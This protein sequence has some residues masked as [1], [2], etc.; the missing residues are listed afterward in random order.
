MNLHIAFD[1]HPVPLSGP[2]PQAH[3]STPEKEK[4]LLTPLRVPSSGSNPHGNGGGA[5]TNAPPSN[6]DPNSLEADKVVVKLE[7]P[8]ANLYLY[9]TVI[10]SFMHL[11]ENIF[12]E[13]QHFTPM[14][15]HYGST[16]RIPTTGIHDNESCVESP[17]LAH[18]GSGSSGGIFDERDYR[19]I[20]VVLDISISNLQAHLLKNCS[21]NDDPCPFAM[22]EDISFEMDKKYRETRLQLILSPVVVRSGSLSARSSSEEDFNKQGHLLL[23][24]LQF[25]GHAMFSELDRPL[26]SDTLE[27]GWLIEVQCGSLLGKISAE[28]L[29]NVFVCLETFIHLAVDKENVLKHPRPYKICQHNTNQK[30]CAHS[31]NPGGNLCATVE[32]VKYKLVRFLVDSVDVH[33]T[34]KDSSLRLQ[35]C[36]IRLAACNLH[37]LNTKQGVSA[38]IK[39]VQLQQYITSNFPLHRPDLEPSHHRD[40]WIETG[41]VRFGPVF[42]EGAI[43]GGGLQ[44]APSSSG[45]KTATVQKVQHDFL[46]RHDNKTKRLWFLWPQPLTKVSPDRLGKC[47][48]VGGC[49]FFGANSNGCGFFEPDA[50][51]IVQRKNVALPCLKSRQGDPGYGQSILHDDHLVAQGCGGFGLVLDQ[52]LPPEWPH[53]CEEPAKLPYSSSFGGGGGSSYYGTHKSNSSHNSSDT[54]KHPKYHRSFSNTKQFTPLIPGRKRSVSTTADAAASATAGRLPLHKGSHSKLNIKTSAE[55]QAKAVGS[56]GKLPKATSMTEVQQQD[57]GE[58]SEEDRSS[59]YTQASSGALPRTESLVSD[60]LS[61]YSLDEDDPTSAASAGKLSH[62]LS[63]H[64]RRSGR[65][66]GATGGSSSPTSTQYETASQGA[67]ASS[68]LSFRSPLGGSGSGGGASASSPTSTQYETANSRGFTSS[69][70]SDNYETASQGTLGRNSSAMSFDTS[71][72]QPDSS[73]DARTL[74]DE[75]ELEDEDDGDDTATLSRPPSSASFISA[76]SEHEDLDLVD[77]HMQVNKP[78][79]DSPLLMSSYISHLTQLRCSYWRETVPVLSHEPHLHGKIKPEL[80]MLE[81]GFSVIKMMDK[82]DTGG[83]KRSSLSEDAGNHKEEEDEDEGKT[84][85]DWDDMQ[86]LNSASAAKEGR[87]DFI[88]SLADPSTHRTTLIVKFRGSIDIILCP[89]MLQSLESL[90]S[91]LASTFKALHPVDVVNHLH[92]RSVDRVESR[93]TLKKEKSLDLQEKLIVEPRD[94]KGKSKSKDKDALASDMFR[95]FEK[96]TSS[97]AQASVTLPKINLMVL[98]ASVV[99]EMCTFSALDRVRDITCVSLLALG[100]QGTTFQFSKTSQSKKT[101]QIYI[102]SQRS[103]FGKKKKSKYKITPD[104]RQNEPFTFESS[105]TQ[106][107]EI[108]MNGSLDKIH[109]QLRR[110]RNNSSIL[111]EALITAIPNHKSKVFFHYVDVPMLG[112]ERSSTPTDNVGVLGQKK[113]ALQQQETT[114]AKMGYNMCECGFE[115]INIKVAKRSC[116]QEESTEGGGGGQEEEEEHTAAH[117]PILPDTVPL[118]GDDSGGS[119]ASHVAFE[120]VSTHEN[121]DGVSHGAESQDSK[122][123]NNPKEAP[124]GGGGG[125]HGRRSTASGS[126]ELKTTWFNFAAPPKTPISKKIDFTK[127]DWNLL[128]TAS[129]SIDAWLGPADRLQEAFTSCMSQYHRRVGATMASLMADALDV[130][131]ENFLKLTKYDKLTALSKTLRDDPS[132]Q[133]C[134]ILLKFMIRGDIADIEANLDLKGVPPLTTLR[135]GIVVLSRQ[136]KNALYTPILI[137]YNLRCRNLKSIYSTQMNLEPVTEEG[138]ELNEEEEEQT[139]D[140]EEEEDEEDNDSQFDEGALLLKGGGGGGPGPGGPRFAAVKNGSIV[141]DISASIRAKLSPAHFSPLSDEVLLLEKSSH[142]HRGARDKRASV[143]GGGGSDD[144]SEAGKILP[145]SVQGSE[146]IIASGDI[147]PT[148]TR[149]QV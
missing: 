118:G 94:V 91:S 79:T 24:G 72:L 13:D 43:S 27:Y 32:E 83:G 14:D 62:S 107:E 149:D 7:I 12:G 5:E 88:T 6:F 42:V 22:V 71:T 122:D 121:D 147:S 52:I 63:S 106:R 96:S 40:I 46:Q 76:V 23:T 95:T 15:V 38:L 3:V 125:Y 77:L 143:G 69:S 28:Q 70:A 137:E 60:V 111:K 59:L 29:Y 39:Q 86:G 134:S 47:G 81:E 82:S 98:Q 48:C 18:G 112:S 11:K 66:R 44:A 115:G 41:C 101:V 64:S 35:A 75:D 1:Y 78:I 92:T 68:S 89:I 148:P 102:Q 17:D 123:P 37:G 10:R 116:N 136:W 120:N 85:F 36:P 2:P 55:S 132:C 130:A 139:A 138:A 25:R 74:R 33:L 117:G 90:L 119:A 103:V 9:G 131:P 56:S 45:G 129:P 30:E 58:K 80:D 128:S 97:Y 93:N 19:P 8:R 50:S 104:S 20:E 51:D 133:L 114:D 140:E 26:G 4:R 21:L 67:S 87:E 61:F 54:P 105:E 135:Q 110:L 146:Q 65:S 31:N 141:S 109:A 127:L 124:S 100:I 73:S 126:V 49:N 53:S 145:Q 144:E 142:H 84:S 34:E 57:G 99:E 16:T 113:H 108:L